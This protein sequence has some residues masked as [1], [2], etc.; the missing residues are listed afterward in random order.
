MESNSLIISWGFLF[1]SLTVTMLVVVTFIS[2]LVHLYSISYM[3]EDPHLP[4]FMAYLSLFTF[5][6][7]MLISAD[8]YV[9]MFLG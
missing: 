6:M 5:F 7:L 2:T 8:N 4:R 1:D 3:S 9:Q